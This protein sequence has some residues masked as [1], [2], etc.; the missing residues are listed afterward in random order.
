MPARRRNPNRDYGPAS[1]P[2]EDPDHLHAMN[3]YGAAVAGMAVDE[4][5]PFA[6]ADWRGPEAEPAHPA[7]ACHGC[8]VH[9]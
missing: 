5:P 9:P 6:L 2:W 3:D 4:R 8:E 7:W 1:N